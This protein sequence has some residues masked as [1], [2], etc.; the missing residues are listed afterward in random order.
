MSKAPQEEDK[1]NWCGLLYMFCCYLCTFTCHC[2][3][4]TSQHY[5]SPN[6]LPNHQPQSLFLTFKAS[7]SPSRGSWSHLISKSDL[8]LNRPYA[9]WLWNRKTLSPPESRSGVVYCIPCLDCECTYVGQS[10][11]SLTVRL[12]EH[13]RAVKARDIDMSALA[14]HTTLTGQTIDWDNASIL[15]SS[16]QYYQRLYLESWY[17]HKQNQPCLLYTSPS[18]RD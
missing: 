5:W 18:P 6:Q 11:R 4:Y 14:E 15:N 12:Q 7:L 16:Q 2:N 9:S 10:G 1:L 17:I 13:K 3:Y 8:D